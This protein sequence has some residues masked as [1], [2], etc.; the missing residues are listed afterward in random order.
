[1]M[2]VYEFQCPH[3]LHVH[4]THTHTQHSS[5]TKDMQTANTT[6]LVP[7]VTTH[8]LPAEIMSL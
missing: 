7:T 4:N 3:A 5:L 8:T 6:K 1:M 2:A